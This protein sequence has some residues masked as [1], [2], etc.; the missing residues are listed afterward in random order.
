MRQG[1][2]IPAAM[3]EQ[4][5]TD[6][7]AGMSA[8]AVGRTHGVSGS[9]V[10]KLARAAGLHVRGRGEQRR[11]DTSS[12]LAYTGEWVRDGL[13]LRPREAS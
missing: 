4:I 3:R 5:V 11:L 9:S 12:D 10:T 6:Y 13:I 1:Q 8:E 7:A 2:R